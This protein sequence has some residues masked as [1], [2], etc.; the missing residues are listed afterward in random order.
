MNLLYLLL[1]VMFVRGVAALITTNRFPPKAVVE[2]THTRGSI[3]T[4]KRLRGRN[5]TWLRAWIALFTGNPD[6][7]AVVQGMRMLA[8]PGGAELDFGKGRVPPW[9][10][11]RMGQTFTEM[12][13]MSPQMANFKLI[14]GDQLENQNV[15]GL[16]I[17]LKKSS[18]DD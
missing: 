8:V 3:P 10:L 2:V 15:P 7:V 16:S 1:F 9:S 6:E 12:K 17:R 5:Y 4:F 18:S 11:E 14:W 13:E